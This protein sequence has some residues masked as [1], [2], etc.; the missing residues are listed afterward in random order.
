MSEEK[1]KTKYRSV[2]S[3]KRSSK[4]NEYYSFYD[5]KNPR[6]RLVLEDLDE[7]G[8]IT[9]RYN[10]NGTMF[11]IE[12]PQVRFDTYVEK[13]LMTV[14]EANEALSKIPDFILEEARIDLNKLQQL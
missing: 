1:S 14:E 6:F 5:S 8:E 13:G 10:L 9:G 11:N 2:F 4:G 3:Q 12:D 7:S